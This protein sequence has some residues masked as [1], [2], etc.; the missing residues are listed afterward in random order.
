MAIPVFATEP[1]RPPNGYEEEGLEV[2]LTKEQIEQIRPWAES[3]KAKLRDLL[4]NTRGL[5]P[6]KTRDLLLE[7]IKRIVIE[8]SPKETERLI[9]FTLNRALK[10]NDMITAEAAKKKMAPAKVVDLEVWLLKRTIELSLRYYKDDLKAVLEGGAINHPY[11]EY[12]IEF[13]H[14]LMSSDK[15]VFEAQS[16]YKIALFVLQLLQ[17]DLYR[18]VPNR[19][20]FSL[21]ISRLATFLGEVKIDPPSRDT[22]AVVELKRIKLEYEKALDGV[23]SVIGKEKFTALIDGVECLFVA[24]D[25]IP[26]YSRFKKIYSI[27]S[28]V[29]EKAE[30]LA[31]SKDGK[32]VAVSYPSRTFGIY[33]IAD[34][35]RQYLDRIDQPIQGLAFSSKK[36]NKLLVIGSNEQ[37]V[38]FESE[39]PLGWRHSYGPIDEP[40]NASFPKVAAGGDKFI[41]YRHSSLTVYQLITGIRK[42]TMSV[43]GANMLALRPD[44]DQIALIPDHGSGVQLWNADT[45][46]ID[47]VI[48]VKAH[49]INYSPNG[50]YLF[51][52]PLN[53]PSGWLYDT[54]N[55]DRVREFKHPSRVRSMAFSADSRLVVVAADNLIYVWSVES[56]IRL[57]VLPGGGHLV[58]ISSD[59]KRII[60]DEGFGNLAVY[61]MYSCRVQ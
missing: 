58:A 52:A 5:S 45:N 22:E 46:E 8:S 31:T 17:W 55:L 4:L 37:A 39:G 30:Y 26:D 41:L 36:A 23:R 6:N 57:A 48:R 25:S 1:L 54:N 34:G 59:G 16:Q 27:A 3:T 40:F 24:S 20:L 51:V 19:A 10:V 11:A 18:D 38:L 9:R 15:S 61:G 29:Y 14:M 49:L 7:E 28:G 21:V 12:G 13:A 43:W 2:S 53:E 32:Y 33:S 47:G 35:R 50:K 42:Y 44:G 60:T 56:G